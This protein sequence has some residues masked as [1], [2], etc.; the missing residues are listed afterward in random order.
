[1]FNLI[2]DNSINII[3]VLDF[4]MKETKFFRWKKTQIDFRL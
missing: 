1:M 3:T 4:C 2:N